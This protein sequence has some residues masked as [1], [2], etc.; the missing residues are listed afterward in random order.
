MIE[1]Y[2]SSVQYSLVGGGGA[3]RVD[4][5]LDGTFG[6]SPRRHRGQHGGGEAIWGRTGR[7]LIPPHGG[8]RLR[9]GAIWTGENS[10]LRR[11]GR[12]P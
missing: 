12:I 6:H 7:V 2:F 1:V 11:G 9:F 3:G 10:G 8:L 5:T 4:G